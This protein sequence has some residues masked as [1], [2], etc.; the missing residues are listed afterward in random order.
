[1]DLFV[2]DMNINLL[3]NNALNL[4][5]YLNISVGNENRKCQY[6]FNKIGISNKLNRITHV[7]TQIKTNTFC[8]LR[9]SSY[10]FYER[11]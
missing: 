8:W 5:K 2:G 6:A 1:M 9:F 4:N 11:P 3:N 7:N 10:F